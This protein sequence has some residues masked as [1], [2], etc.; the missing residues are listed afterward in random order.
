MST[1]RWDYVSFKV[2]ETEELFIDGGRD[3]RR[4]NFTHHPNVVEWSLNED[5]TWEECKEKVLWGT[6]G[7]NG[8][9]PKTW[10][11]LSK[12]TTEHL[13]AILDTQKHLSRS[14]IELIEDILKD[15]I[16]YKYL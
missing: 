2:S 16:V 13:Q 4:S 10:V 8:D 12:C 3:Y 11:P 9:E 6:Y 7:I 5:S 15:R 1:N 14:L